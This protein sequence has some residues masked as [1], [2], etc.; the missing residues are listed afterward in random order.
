VHTPLLGLDAAKPCHGFM[1]IPVGAILAVVRQCN[2]PTTYANVL[3]NDREMLVFC[4]DLSTHAVMC[5]IPQKSRQQKR[6][7]K[8]KAKAAGSSS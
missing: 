5:D 1:Y 7:P 8:A 2:H 6:R 4:Q 3:W